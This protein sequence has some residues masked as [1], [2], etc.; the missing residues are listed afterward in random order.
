M[1]YMNLK[2]WDSLPKDVQQ[3]F[4]DLTPEVEKR[5]WQGQLERTQQGLKI[6]AD[7]GRTFVKVTPDQ[8]KLWDALVKPV[9]GT[10]L[11][12][13]KSKGVTEGPDILAFMQ[14][15]SAAAWSKAP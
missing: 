3:I 8:R 9:D 6:W 15:Q 14:Q 13:M 2:T 5:A 1:I 10:W 12:N 7:K 11:D 4:I